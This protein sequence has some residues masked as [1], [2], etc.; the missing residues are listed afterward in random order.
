MRRFSHVPYA[1]DYM[2][3]AVEVVR[4]HF[5]GQLAGRKILDIPAGNGWVSDELS[6]GSAEAVSAD[7][8]EER[9]DYAQVDME[10]TLPFL[11]GEFDAIV[12]LEGIEHVLNPEALFAEFARVLKSGGVL[13]LSTPNVQNFYSRWQFLCTGYLFQ[14]DP[15]NKATR[16]P[17]ERLDRGHVS[18]VTLGQLLYWSEQRGLRVV[19]VTGGRMK[20]LL[21]LPLFLPFVLLGLWW[22][23]SDW[24]RT[25]GEERTRPMLR[26]YFGL[27]LLFSRSL[28]YVCTK[29]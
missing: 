6:Q 21:F 12:S 2:A 17:Q 28:V 8:N 20:K 1:T 7:I 4:R 24:K 19:R 29:P 22:A 25:S 5:E 9:P 11:D 23:W 3:I 13:V 27:R 15:F 14:F 16:G 26:H 18:P 10:R